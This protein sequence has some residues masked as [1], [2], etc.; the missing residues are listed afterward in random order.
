MRKGLRSLR[1]RV[2]SDFL[3]GS[4]LEA[5]EQFLEV[6]LGAGY[7]ISSV[8]GLWR[9][10]QGD[11]LDPEHRY[12]ALRHDVDT[13]PRTAAAMWG[14]DRRLGVQSSYFFRLSTLDPALMADIAQEGGEVSYHYEEL[15]SVAKRRRLRSRSDALAHVPEA[16]DLF[17]QNLGRLR[18]MTGLPMRVVAS[19]GDFAG[20]RLGF[21]NW[22]ILDDP[23]FR[24]EVGIDLETYDK[25]FLGCL[26]R[27]YIDAPSPRYWEPADPTAA[28]KAGEPVISVLVHPRQWRADPMVNGRDDILRVI[29]GLRFKLPARPGGQP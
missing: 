17:A 27:R 29:E 26:P 12:F 20:R 18:A 23:D 1:D 15:S 10:I 19:H 21:T 11:G 14:V 6:A 5:Y 13:D 3:M 24:R 9:R 22:V 2:Y 4:R 25:A 16:Q 28:I 7:R 8:G